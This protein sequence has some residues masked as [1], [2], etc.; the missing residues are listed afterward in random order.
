MRLKVSGNYCQGWSLVAPQERAAWEADRGALP[1]CNGALGMA[2]ANI[3]PEAMLKPLC[4]S[5]LQTAVH[6]SSR[7]SILTSNLASNSPAKHRQMVLIPPVKKTMAP[8]HQPVGYNA[9][10]SQNSCSV[11]VEEVML[12]DRG[13]RSTPRLFTAAQSWRKAAT[14]RRHRVCHAALAD[15]L[16][17]HHIVSKGWHV[18]GKTLKPAATLLVCSSLTK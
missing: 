4:T 15:V 3:Q 2:G 16:H 8:H 10:H 14:E 11:P 9:E 12:N 1:S 18:C 7:Q 13:F 17:P 6:T 5:H